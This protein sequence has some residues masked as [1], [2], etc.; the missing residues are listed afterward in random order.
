M[1]IFRDPVLFAAFGFGA[2]LSKKAPGTVGTLVAIPFYLLLA[3]TDLRVYAAVLLGLGVGAV[4][5]CQQASQRLG[6]HD[7]PGIV[8]DEIVG[9]LAAMVAVTPSWQA[10]AVGFGL[11]RFFDIF[12]PWPIRFV[13]ERVPGGVGIVLDDVVAGL[14]AALLLQILRVAGLLP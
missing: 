12:K 13:D 11:F 6:V 8:L 9:F 3:S 1:N 5:I 10:V 4:W 7:H 2:G 14:L